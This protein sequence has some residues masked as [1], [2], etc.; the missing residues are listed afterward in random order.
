MTDQGELLQAHLNMM[1]GEAPIP[2]AGMQAVKQAYRLRMRGL[3]YTSIALIMGVYHGAWFST[4]RWSR[5]CREMGAPT[6]PNMVRGF[7][8]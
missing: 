2:L 1:R 3:P 7:R 8:P 6:M 5:V 4:T